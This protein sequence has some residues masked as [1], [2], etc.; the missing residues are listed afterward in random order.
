MDKKKKVIV[1][2]DGFNFYYGLKHNSWR[3]YYWLDL[4]KFFESFM[5]EDQELVKV[6]YF[7]AKP[8]DIDK[9]RRQNALFQA[10]QA[11]PKF[12]LILGKYL[13]KTMTCHSCGYVI[14]T[15]E[16]KETDVRIA[17]QIV[18]DAYKKN[19]DIAII[20]SADSDMVPA[21][22]LAQE[23]GIITYVYFPPTHYSSNLASLCYNRPLYLNRYESRFRHSL[24]PDNVTLPSGYVLPIPTEWKSWQLRRL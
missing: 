10:N 18:A 19:C 6:K 1:Y 22:E 16:E 9:S 11:N 7:S 20:V 12:E 13:H 8:N 2:I 24:L 3:R 17:T 14:N 15:Y 23:A 4:V 5:R 21:I